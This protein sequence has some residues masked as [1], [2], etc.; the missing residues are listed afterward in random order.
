[1]QHRSCDI[2]AR[3][4]LM[5]MKEAGHLRRPAGWLILHVL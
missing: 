3:E 2:F 4:I 5:Q 1:M